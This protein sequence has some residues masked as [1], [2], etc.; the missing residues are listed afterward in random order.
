MPSVWAPRTSSG[1]ASTSSYAA[2]WRASSPTCGPFPC[3][4]TSSLPSAMGASC[5]AATRTFARCASA[6]IGW[7]RRSS[8]LPPRA[9]TM[10]MGGSVPDRGDEDRLDRV[11]P[12][13]GLVEHDRRRRLEHLVGDLELGQPMLLEH[14]L[15][16]LR[17]RVVERGQAV[18]E[19]RVRVAGRGHRGGVDL[20]RQ[21]LPD[22][23]RPDLLGLAHRDPHVR[24]Q[25]VCA[26]DALGHRVG[27]RDPG[28]A[29]GGD[30]LA[31]LD[32][33]ILR[34]PLAGTDEPDVHAQQRASDEERVAHVVPG[35]AEV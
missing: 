7:P 3:E 12:V 26:L 27:E 33:G 6:V 22:P 1:Y 2:A 19:L 5:W 9:T 29:L 34:P 15:A 28:A 11:H 10:R 21:E 14:L 23:L 20:V 13:L 17:V 30:R 24:V 32:E 35:V 18:H 25:E 8:A 16:D 31:L 4:M